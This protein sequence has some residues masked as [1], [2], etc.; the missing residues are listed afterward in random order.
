M[1]RHGTPAD[2]QGT[3]GTCRRELEQMTKLKNIIRYFGV[4][5]VVVA[6]MLATFAVFQT[7]IA[8]EIQ[9]GTYQILR[10]SALLQKTDVTKFLNM[11]VQRAQAV[12]QYNQDADNATITNMLETELSDGGL[13][14]RTGYADSQGCVLHGDLDLSDVSQY[15]WFQSG[16]NGESSISLYPS[17]TDGESNDILIAIPTDSG[18][19]ADGVLFATVSNR[20]VSDIIETSAFDGEAVSGICDAEGNLIFTEWEQA[21]SFSEKNVFRLIGED[22]LQRGLT[23]A[24]LKQAVL[25]GE[26]MEFSFSYAGEKYYTVIEP[27]G[28]R[29]W[30]MF[31]TIDA[32]TADSIQRQV[33]GYVFAMFAI[34]LAVGM[35]MTLQAYMHERATVRRLEQDKELLRQVGERYVLI[36]RLSNEVLFMINMEDGSI[37]FND[38][39]EAMFGFMPPKCSIDDTKDCFSLVVESDWPQFSRF[40]ER[41]KAGAA[42]AHEEVRMV[43]A[44]GVSRWKHLEV[45]T[46]FDSEGRSKEAVGKISDIHRQRQSLQRL[47][48]KADSD[49]LT[50]LLNRSA[51][52]RLTRQ[53]LAGE[54]K[55]GL[56]AFFM[57]DFDNFKQVNDT[58]GH[59]EG[60][61]MLAAFAYAVKRLFRADDL[62]AR[63]GGDEYAMLMKAID[64]DES[65]LEKAG[66]IRN[67]MRQVGE[68][69]GV[70][71]TASIGIALFDRDGGTFELLYQAA[72]EALYCVKGSGKDDCAFYCA[73]KGAAKA[74]QNETE[75]Q[76]NGTADT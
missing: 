55:T 48:R 11:L 22:S 29:D 41:M 40:V 44:H 72:D 43:N 7:R 20:A 59:A 38:N 56:H 63:I 68:E 54:G 2:S 70:G 42:E 57:L 21:F 76:E 27:L 12:M 45:Y 53:F 3:P 16:L 65:A 26:G 5:L 4:P 6:V 64:S 75:G 58:R 30:Y 62:V 74:D 10:E 69:F 67:A 19:A 13:N 34:V 17:Q 46:V 49:S 9:Q 51:M 47:K 60:D 8:S 36:N 66:Q 15:E 33:G 24:D 50:G 14:A 73:A 32:S 37:S 28:I 31:S 52:E 39:F 25:D 71:V 18:G 35:A 61:R 23:Q 1:R